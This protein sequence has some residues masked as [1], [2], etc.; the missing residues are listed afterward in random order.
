MSR[1]KKFIKNEEVSGLPYRVPMIKKEKNRKINPKTNR[2][3]TFRKIMYHETDIPPE[4]RTFENLP[5]Y[6]DKSSKVRF[7]D[8]LLIKP[9]KI[10]P[11]HSACSFGK[12]D[13][14]GKTWWG[15]SHRSVYGFKP[16]DE[17]TDKVSGF[18]YMKQKSPFTIKND[19]EARDV[20]IAFA[21]SVS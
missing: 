16:G 5:R 3:K 1:L 13:A 8:W 17:I 20:A 21:K 2:E 11:E 10:H 9:E 19:K 15:W 6:A 4:K 14:D 18:E 7:Q 12:S